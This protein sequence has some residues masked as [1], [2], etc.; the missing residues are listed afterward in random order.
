VKYILQGTIV[1]FNARKQVINDGYI[2]INNQKISFVT[3]SDHE[4]PTEFQDTKVIRVNGYIYPGLIDLH[5]HLSYNF[6]DLWNIDRKFVDRYQWRNLKKYK[7]EISAPA[8]LLVNSNPVEVVKYSEVKALV[9]G[10]TSIGGLA[11][12]N[13]AYAAWLLRNIEVERFG[14]SDPKIYQNIMRLTTHEDFVEA[15]KK[16]REG[17]AYIYHLAEGT[18]TNLYKEFEDLVQHNLVRD[19]LVGIHCTALT[20][21]HWNIMGE[22]KAKMV[23]SPL[24]NL[25]LYGKTADIPSAIQSDTLICLGSDWSPTGSKSLLWELKVAHLLNQEVFNNMFSDRELVEMVTINPAQA[26]GLNDKIGKIISGHFA[27]LVIFDIVDDDPYRNLI[28]CNEIDLK[29]SIIDGRPRYGD[30]DILSGI[31]TEQVIENVTVGSAKKGINI[32]QPGVEHGDMTFE[33]VRANLQNALSNPTST[34]RRLFATLRS[35]QKGVE[36][37]RLVLQ[38]EGEEDHFN[39]IYQL[40]KED[41]QFALFIQKNF[42]VKTI[43]PRK[44]DSLTM[45]DDIDFFNT[46]NYNPNIPSYLKKLKDYAR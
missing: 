5:N 2:C 46:V 13:R 43:H 34:A 12:F 32:F 8:K 19:K 23:W 3:S 44:L 1:T 39:K 25:L 18:S 24:S 21:Q 33:E 17:K 36:P 16:M 27:D 22:N 10:V 41:N 11:R 26:I 28:F 45:Y 7:E 20:P 42:D 14:G 38:E 15:D 31:E 29:L 30:M 40:A 35:M 37:L 6:L 4:L 9:G